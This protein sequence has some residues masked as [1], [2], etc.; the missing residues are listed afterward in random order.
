M[1]YYSSSSY[2]HRKS[3]NPASSQESFG[4]P[5]DEYRN[6]RRGQDRERLETHFSHQGEARSNSYTGSHSAYRD[7]GLSQPSR[8]RVSEVR[9]STRA[10]LGPSFDFTDDSY[11]SSRTR[12]D[13]YQRSRGWIDD[14][15]RHALIPKKYRDE[16]DRW[17]HEDTEDHDSDQHLADHVSDAPW[18]KHVPLERNILDVEPVRARARTTTAP[19]PRR[20]D[21]GYCSGEYERSEKFTRPPLPVSKFSWDSDETPSPRR[22]LRELFRRGE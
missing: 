8:H 5:H 16:F 2:G 14:S 7:A 21:S 13:S 4:L 10:T 19:A 20:V 12:N 9:S 3:R 11:T 15:P 18:R 22:N 6:L 17:W 1:A